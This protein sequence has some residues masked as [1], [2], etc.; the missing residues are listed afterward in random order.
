MPTILLEMCLSA[1]E[2]CCFDLSLSGDL[3][4]QSQAHAQERPI[5]GVTA[6]VMHLG[7]TVTW[8]SVHLSGFSDGR[9]S[10]P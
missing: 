5:A 1:Q 3:H 7:D 6:G 10:Q 2:E 4:V 8:E 9:G